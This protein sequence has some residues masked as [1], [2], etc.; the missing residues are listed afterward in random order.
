MKLQ[1]TEHVFITVSKGRYNFNAHGKVL[2]SLDMDNTPYKR[3]LAH[4]ESFASVHIPKPTKQAL[5]AVKAAKMR[6]NV[7]GWAS[8]MYA[9]NRGVPAGMYRMALQNEAINKINFS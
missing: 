2:H 1:Q 6:H 8:R 7:G 4:W 9:L 3:L 5:T